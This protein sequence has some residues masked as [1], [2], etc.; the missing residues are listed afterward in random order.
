MVKNN[1]ATESL[2]GLLVDLATTAKTSL[3]AAINEVASALASKVDKVTGYGLS[4]N[5]YSDTEKNRLAN[6]SGT[7]TGDQD[8]SALMLKTAFSGLS[9]ISVGNSQ[10]GSPTT[11]DLWVDTSA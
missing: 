11:G 4:K 2:T 3:V 8:L 6:T 1:L 10:P 5:D 7:N 9:K